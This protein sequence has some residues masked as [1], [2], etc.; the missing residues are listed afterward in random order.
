M[1]CLFP[2]FLKNDDPMD[3]DL[4]LIRFKVVVETGWETFF[5][6][7]VEPLSTSQLQTKYFAPYKAI[8]R[9]ELVSHHVSNNTVYDHNDNN[10]VILAKHF[11]LI[12]A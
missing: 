11:L 8:D 7:F 4:L 10:V 1:Y 5:S 2:P 6:V 12:D 3:H 9:A